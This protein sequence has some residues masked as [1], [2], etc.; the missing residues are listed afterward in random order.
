MTHMD[1]PTAD[2]VILDLLI[3]DVEPTHEN[4]TAAIAAYPQHREALVE[5]FASLG[6]Q[7][8]LAPQ[9]PSAGCAVERFASIGVSR[10]LELHHR[11]SQEPREAERPASS[12][13]AARLLFLARQ[14]GLDDA[15]LAARTGLDKGLVIKLDRRRISGPRPIEVFRRLGNELDIPPAHVIAA[16][17][18][19]PIPS[20]RGN[21]RKARSKII[22]TTETFEQAIRASTLTDDAKSFWLSLLANED[23]LKA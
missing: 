22:V 9:T 13:G 21:L 5:F 20:S 1:K 8:A 23:E 10:V 14:R 6:V 3:E 16:T 12:S 7:S 15:S 19:P 4:L 11:I 17:T 2:D 18:G